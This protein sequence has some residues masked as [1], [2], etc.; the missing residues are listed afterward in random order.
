MLELEQAK[1]RVQ[2]LRTVIEKNNRL[3][4]DQDAPELEDFE[5]D[6]L[7]R[8]LKE[9]EAAYPELVTPT[10]PTQHVGGPPSGRF[11]KV[12]HAVKMESLLDA[13]PMTNCATLTIASRKPVSPRNMWSRSKLMVFPVAWNMKTASWFGL[14]PVAMVLSVKM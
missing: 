11:A 7:T 3:Y 14:L 5:Y 8:E 2:E 13:F 1:Q 12:T 6:A 4:Y 10:S 9:L